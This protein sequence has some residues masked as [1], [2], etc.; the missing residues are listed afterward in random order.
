MAEILFITGLCCYTIF[1]ILMRVLLDEASKDEVRP[2]AKVVVA[3]LW[4]ITIPL[5]LFFILRSYR[6]E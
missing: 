2:W 3:F 1:Y 5:G 6:N 4:P